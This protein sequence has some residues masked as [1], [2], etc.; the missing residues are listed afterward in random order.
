[1]EGGRRIM[2]NGVIITMII[3]GTVLAIYLIDKFF[4]K[5]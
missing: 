5:N 3:C 4:D 1:M 2:S